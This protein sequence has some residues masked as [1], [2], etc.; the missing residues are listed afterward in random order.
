MTIDMVRRRRLSVPEPKVVRLDRVLVY[1]PRKRTW[2]N[3]TV[4]SCTCH[5]DGH[6]D[7]ASWR[8]HWIV[9]LDRVSRTGRPLRVHVYGPNDIGL[10]SP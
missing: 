2:E 1:N 7:V 8:W 3:G 6:G 5:D 10:L 9:T 4:S